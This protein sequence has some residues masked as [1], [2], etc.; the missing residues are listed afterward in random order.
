MTR[1]KVYRS[2]EL[3]RLAGVST[4]TLRHYERIGVLARPPRATNG[5]RVYPA[6][7]LDRV[8]VAQRALRAGFSLPELRRI[9]GQRD[10]GGS[11]C[12]MVLSLTRQKH[13]ELAE[14]IRS[15]QELKAFLAKLTRDWATRLRK[16]PPGKK[17]HLLDSLAEKQ[18]P[19][20][21]KRLPQKNRRKKP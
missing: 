4:D 15:L 10:T 21:A 7:S 12:H 3:A 18:L 19:T 5:Y 13:I 11:P 6:S 20:G 2:G 17:A 9:L 16:T 14:Q 8:L 1:E